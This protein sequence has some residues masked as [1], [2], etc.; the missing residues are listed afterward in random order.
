MDAG[1]MRQYICEAFDGVN[2]VDGS[3]DTFFLY[4]PDG[5]LPAERQIP[6]AT[7]VT[8]DHYDSV[9][10]LNRPGAY[11]LNV[12]LT[13]ATYTAWFGAA[14]THADADGVLDTGFDYAAVDTVVPHPTYACQH[15]VCVVNPGEATLETVRAL[16]VE[17]HRFAARKYANHQARREHRPEAAG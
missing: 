6:F 16:L 1:E 8:G 12:G 4:D 15:W 2:A 5:D 14:P 10:K 9:S 17:A 13:K 7:I 11:R 3:G